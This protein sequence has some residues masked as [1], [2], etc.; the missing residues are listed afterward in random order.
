TDLPEQTPQFA[1]LFNTV[2][3]YDTHA[4]IPEFYESVNK[5]A[6]PAEKTAIISV[7]WDPGLFSINGVLSEAFL[8]KGETYTF[9]GKGLSQGNSD[10]VRRVDGVQYGV[11]Y[12]ISSETAIE[13]VSIGENQELE[14]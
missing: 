14:T 11:Q 8:P 13:L 3:S 4:L 1:K 10:A 12:T 5:S 6:E 2:D 9:W 7:G